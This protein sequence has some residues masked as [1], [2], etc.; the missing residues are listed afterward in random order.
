MMAP[1]KKVE[2]MRIN[3]DPALKKLI[4]LLAKLA[5]IPLDPK[6]ISISWKDGLPN[7]DKEQSQIEMTDVT[8]GITSKKASA[9]R[10]YG[11][12]SDQAD[13][14]QMQIK[15]ELALQGGMM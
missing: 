13:A 8:A 1:L 10:R 15:E 14:D 3:V 4:W 2:R 11:W 7:D 12:T 6:E 9:M 5:N